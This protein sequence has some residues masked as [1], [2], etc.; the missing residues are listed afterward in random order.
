MAKT[1]VNPKLLK[2]ALLKVS[3]L[4]FV[5]AFF[6]QGVMRRPEWTGEFG[7]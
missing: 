7:I 3:D 4:E 2:D 1:A 5:V 6:F